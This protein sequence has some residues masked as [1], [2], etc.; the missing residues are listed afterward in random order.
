MVLKTTRRWTQH[1]AFECFEV[2][3][4]VEQPT[5]LTSPTPRDWCDGTTV[6]G[7]AAVLRTD[8]LVRPALVSY[9]FEPLIASPI[10]A[11]S[12]Q[13]RIKCEDKVA[14][15]TLLHFGCVKPC[16]FHAAK[17]LAR[18]QTRSAGSRAGRAERGRTA[19]APEGCCIHE[20]SDERHGCSVEPNV[21]VNRG[22]AVG[23]QARAGENVPCTT[24]P[25]LVARRWG[26]G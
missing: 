2:G 26:S 8:F 24:S 10:L 20:G 25:G 3:R 16:R 12:K 23:H 18:C 4:A 6:A 17:A 14:T 19:M 22:P 7:A 5:S 9:G 1:T 11:F 13:G 21:R 15:D